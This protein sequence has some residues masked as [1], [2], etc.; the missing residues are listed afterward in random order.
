MSVLGLVKLALAIACGGFLI[1]AGVNKLTPA[2]S[3]DTYNTL[4]MYS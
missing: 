1:L 3:A 2:F 4:D